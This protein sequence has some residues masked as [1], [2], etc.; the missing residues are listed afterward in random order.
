MG[1][2]RSTAKLTIMMRGD[3]ILEF[4]WLKGATVDLE[5]ARRSVL[6]ATELVQQPTPTLVVMNDVLI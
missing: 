2:T 5:G 4:R 3:S 1:Q 6:A